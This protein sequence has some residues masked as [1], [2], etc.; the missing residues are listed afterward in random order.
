MNDFVHRISFIL[1]SLNS[2][3]V[4]NAWLIYLVAAV[5]ALAIVKALVNFIHVLAHTFIPTGVNVFILYPI[6]KLAM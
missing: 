2:T 1:F 3:R 6:I 4:G 5:G